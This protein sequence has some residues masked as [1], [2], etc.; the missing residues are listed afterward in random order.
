MTKQISAALAKVIPI[1]DEERVSVYIS[2]PVPWREGPGAGDGAGAG[3][4]AGT[5]AGAG[6][7]GEGE[8]KV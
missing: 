5:D 7:G 2:Q 8:I 3:A 4:G 6:A 1:N